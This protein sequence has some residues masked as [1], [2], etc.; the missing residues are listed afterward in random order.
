MLK[1]IREQNHRNCL[2]DSS[3]EEQSEYEQEILSCSDEDVDKEKAQPTRNDDLPPADPVDEPEID[4]GGFNMEDIIKANNKN[5]GR[6]DNIGF[7]REHNDELYNDLVVEE[8]DVDFESEE[9]QALQYTSNKALGR[10]DGNED[11]NGTPKTEE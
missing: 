4:L 6:Y 1:Q 8:D 5:L 3:S 10:L 11:L 9:I 7:G 2:D